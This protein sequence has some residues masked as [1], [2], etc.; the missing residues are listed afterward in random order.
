MLSFPKLFFVTLKSVYWY[1]WSK[2]LQQEPPPQTPPRLRVVQKSDCSLFEPLTAGYY[3]TWTQASGLY[4]LRIK[5]LSPATIN[6]ATQWEYYDGRGSW[7]AHFSD[8]APIVEWPN[9]CGPPSI[10]WVGGAVR[11]FVLVVGTPTVGLEMAPTLDTWIAESESLTGPYKLVQYL[12]KFGN[13]VRMS[14][15]LSQH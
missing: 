6:D 14:R 8:L 13:Q 7:S 10:T 15:V 4:V 9:R 12:S 2:A 3:C 5:H 11:K 1:L